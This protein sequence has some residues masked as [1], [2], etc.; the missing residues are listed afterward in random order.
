MATAAPLPLVQGAASQG[1]F[2]VAPRGGRLVAV[3]GDYLEPARSHGTAAWSDDGGVTWHDVPGGA[4]G[5]RS[6][7]VWLDDDRLLAVGS[8]GASRSFD[9]GRSWQACGTLG[10]HRVAIGGDGSIWACGSDGRVARL[11]LRRFA[12]APALPPR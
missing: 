6:A 10:F 1:A 7:V 3:G 4:G 8:H 12:A 5:Y 11:D 2:A 9:G